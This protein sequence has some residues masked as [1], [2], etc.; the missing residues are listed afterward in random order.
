MDVEG[1]HSLA[2][3]WPMLEIACS[4]L[5]HSGK[6]RVI[7]SVSAETASEPFS[8]VTDPTA[9][10]TLF[11]AVSVHLSYRTKAASLCIFLGK[12]GVLVMA[13]FTL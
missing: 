8:R 12:A 11:N 7:T 1:Y 10:S 6:P 3:T 5:P 13:Q 4:F 2:I 9:G